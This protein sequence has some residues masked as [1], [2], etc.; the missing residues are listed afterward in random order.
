MAK[1]RVCSYGRAASCRTPCEGP[2]D[3]EI[4][5]RSTRTARVLDTDLVCR[6]HSQEALIRPQVAASI[7][8]VE[9]R[10]ISA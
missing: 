5:Y 7:A 3:Q 1:E 10:Q 9:L 2:V 8:Q 4:V 6:R